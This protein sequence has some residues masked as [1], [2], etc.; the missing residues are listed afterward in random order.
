MSVVS[1]TKKIL[2]RLESPRNCGFFT[3]EQAETRQMRLV[4][5]SLGSFEG[6]VLV[7]LGFLVD[8]TDG[9]VVDAKFQA[10]GPASLLAASD[11]A[12]DLTVGKSYRQAGKLTAD[13]IDHALRDREK[14]EA[15]DPLSYS[16]INLVLESLDMALASCHDIPLEGGEPYELPTPL[17]DQN[18]PGTPIANFEALSQDQKI[19]AIEE[20]LNREVRPYVAMDEG[21]VEIYNL[22]GNELIISYKGACTSCFSSVGA[23]LSSIQEILRSHVHPALIVVPHMEG[24]NL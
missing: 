7:K 3:R 4:E 8:P 6:G 10:F 9:I 19:Q 17:P 1:F 2:A 21:G 16:F 5:G 14:E 15:F 22:I 24:L 18:L 20:V 13:Q 11:V 12:C 23:T